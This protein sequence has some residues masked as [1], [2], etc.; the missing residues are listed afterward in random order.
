MTDDW[1][2]RLRDALNAEYRGGKP[3]VATL[4]TVDADGR[5][6]ARS[7]VCRRLLDD[8]TTWYASDARSGKNADVRA[9][10]DAEAV[11][12]LAGQREQFRLLGRVEVLGEGTEA[13]ERLALWREM[14]DTA[15]ALFA[16][17]PPGQPR[18]TDPAS[19]QERLGAHVP[20]PASFEVLVLRPEQ[21]ERLGLS[22]H[23]HNR[24]RWRAADGWQG[25]ALNP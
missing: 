1:I 8:G 13:P 24:R 20:P 11:F 18:V 9:R 3:W 25:I 23:P 21:V 10:P 6:R 14:S 15:R 12:W 4:A 19:F 17:P 2:N 5:P 16:W 7:V 22:F